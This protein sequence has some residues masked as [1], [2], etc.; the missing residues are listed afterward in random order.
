MNDT[1]AAISSALGKGAIAI[2]RISGSEAIEI[3]GKVFSNKNII[4]AKSHTVHYGRILNGKEIV[5]EVLVTILRSPKTYTKED[6]VEIGCHGGMYVANKV[7]E[8]LLIKGCRLAEPGEFT[9]RAFL[10]GR[11]DLT[12][13]ESVCDMIE[14]KTAASLKMA[15]F[16]IRGDIRNMIVSFQKKL[17]S[18]IT[19]IEVSI[20][21]PEYEDEADITASLLP[22]IMVL[23]QNIDDILKKAK[24]STILKQGIVTAIIGPP[25]VGKSS[26]LNALLREEKAIVTEIPGTT[27]DIVEGQVNIGGVLLNLID[28]AGIRYTEDVI[29][30]IG[31]EKT[32]EV[33]SKA[34]LVIMVFDYNSPLTESD[35]KLLNLTSGACR[36]F[37]INKNDLHPR[38]DLNLFDDYLL[39]STFNPGDI[40]KLETKIKQIL[41]ISDTADIDYTYVGNARQI[42]K[43]Q[44]TKE[45][46]EEACN[47][48]NNNYPLDIINIDLSNAWRRLAEIL[49]TSHDVIIDEIFANFCLG[50]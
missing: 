26:L 48:V 39:M 41:N 1:I 20:D 22:G 40:E 9:K 6:I 4:K 34:S 7:L 42:A 16:G 2:I 31:V 19:H 5:D 10:N 11:I 8:L 45:A 36:I 44:Q 46:L 24:A 29:E 47:S 25:N 15:N 18:Y 17:T 38:I 50:K 33:I 23:I 37:V 3:I 21:Y 43:L 13:A 49:G 12:Q 35:L 32:K 28:T 27:R 14:A 30:K